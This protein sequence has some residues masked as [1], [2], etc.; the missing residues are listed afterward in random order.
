MIQGL[1]Q[2]PCPRSRG[3]PPAP[4]LRCR[5]LLFHSSFRMLLG[6]T[7]G[8]GPMRPPYPRQQG[9]PPCTRSA[10]E[11]TDCTNFFPHE[12]SDNGKRAHG[13][14]ENEEN[15]GRES[16]LSHRL[17]SIV[18]P[19]CFASGRRRNAA[20]PWWRQGRIQL[21]K[22]Q[23][24]ICENVCARFSISPGNCLCETDCQF[25]LW[26]KGRC[27][28]WGAGAKPR[29]SPQASPGNCLFDTNCH[30]RRKGAGVKPRMVPR[31]LRYIT[32]RMKE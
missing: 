22:F 12:T 23:S 29:R 7:M 6:G 30:F 4:I 2:P 32:I 3:I 27:P 20:S 25:R 5:S 24:F 9:D 17:F 8:Q 15:A 19:G 31:L 14:N 21:A 11:K 18:F 10:I 26:V 28:L 1:M 13:H 16:L